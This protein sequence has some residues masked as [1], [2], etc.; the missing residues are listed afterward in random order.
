[1]PCDTVQRIWVDISLDQELIK[2]LVKDL[3]G[4]ISGNYFQIGEYRCEIEGTNIS[5]LNSPSKTDTVVNILKI[6][7]SNTILNKASKR[8]GWKITITGTRTDVEVPIKMEM[9]RRTGSDTDTLKINVLNSGL[10]RIETDTV[11]PA[12]HVN[13]EKLLDFIE[14]QSGGKTERKRKHSVKHHEHVHVHAHVHR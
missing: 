10:I 12:N 6:A 2:K 4:E 5:C 1:M 7:Y 8:F 9:T 14:K 3:G 11:S 13:A